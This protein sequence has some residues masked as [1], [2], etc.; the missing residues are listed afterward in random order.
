MLGGRLSQPVGEAGT[1]FYL[2][3]VEVGVV[4]VGPVVAGDRI[5]SS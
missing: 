3:V 2:G 1:S 4:K 5:T